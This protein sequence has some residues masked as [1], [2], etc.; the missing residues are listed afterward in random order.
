MDTK[1][2]LTLLEIRKTL[3]ADPQTIFDALTQT[4]KLNQ[5]FF[6]MDGGSAETEIDLRKGGKY[7]IGMINDGGETVA[8]PYGEFL[9]IEPPH[10]LSMTWK[11]DGFVDYSILTFE[12]TPTQ[13]GTELVLTH[14]L[15][16][17]TIEPHR[18]GWAT[19]L[20]HLKTLIQ[21]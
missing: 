11:T 14:E 3:K 15:P 18:Q 20:T 8:T 19:C 10:K 5:W 12:L 21:N 13:N 16:E 17:P 6:A 4:D 1:P 7:S 9:V 2:S